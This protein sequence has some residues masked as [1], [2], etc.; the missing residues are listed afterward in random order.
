MLTTGTDQCDCHV[1]EAVGELSHQVLQV[2]PVGGKAQDF[3]Q[4][5][6]SSVVV[7]LFGVADFLARVAVKRKEKEHGVVIRVFSL[8]ND[9]EPDVEREVFHFQYKDWPDH[10]AALQLFC[11][12]RFDNAFLQDCRLLQPRSGTF[13]I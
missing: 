9:A 7:V 5:N 3:W 8:T 11:R 1:D 6:V 2:L 12:F 10:G 4:D 13:F